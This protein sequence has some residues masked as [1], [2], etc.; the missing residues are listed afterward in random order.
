LHLSE[1]TDLDLL[2]LAMD[3][4]VEYFQEELIPVAAQLTERLVD[5]LVSCDA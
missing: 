4:M 1:E 5:H 3:K 2:N